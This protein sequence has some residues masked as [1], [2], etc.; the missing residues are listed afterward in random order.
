MDTAPVSYVL[1]I[2][3]AR[4]ALDAEMLGY[5]R[6]IS[7]KT[8]LII[9]DGSGDEVFDAHAAR[10]ASFCRHVRP[11]P[12]RSCRNGKVM[13]VL[14]GIHLATHDRLIIADD[15]VRYDEPSLRKVRDLLERY[16]AVQPQNYFE[17]RPW[18]AQWDTARTLINRA[19]GRDWPGTIA[20]RRSLLLRAGGYDGDVLFENLELVR[21][22]EVLGGVV[23]A[24]LDCY[25]KRLPPTTA[26]FFSQR[27][28]QAYDEFA[29]P[30]RLAVGLCTLPVVALSARKS[31]AATVVAALV[32]MAVASRGRARGQGGRYFGW[33]GV[34]WAPIWV[35][36]RGICSW[37]AL[38]WRL[39]GG[40]PY[41]TSVIR[42][43]A[44]SRD[45]IRDIH[46]FG[47]DPPRLRRVSD[48]R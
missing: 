25:V 28:R 7:E 16:D 35:L 9:V 34:L 26:H 10:W 45:E 15:D 18:H 23:A 2:R 17:P 22:I 47:P 1:P 42:T 6:W 44:H 19:F 33:G 43:A 39:R 30:E 32:P 37:I 29:R 4:P 20:V 14:T 13:G 36:E 38:W 3:R 41:G 24:P 31:R 8:E 48:R 40:C 12:S 5:L 21:T 46:S 11:D 27:V